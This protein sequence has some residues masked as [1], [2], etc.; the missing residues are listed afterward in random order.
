MYSKHVH[1]I[2]N[3]GLSRPVR[4]LLLLLVAGGFAL[5]Q[6][7]VAQIVVVPNDFASTPGPDGNRYPFDLGGASPPLSSMR[8]QQV[9]AG[10]QFSALP[11]VGSDP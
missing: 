9:Y 8:Y 11:P 10:S 6:R 2:A 7:A 1:T 4:V 5:Q 3:V